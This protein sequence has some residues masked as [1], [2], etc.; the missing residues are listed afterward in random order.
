MRFIMTDWRQ[1]L[2]RKPDLCS[3]QLCASGTRIP[4]TVILANLADGLS[5]DEVLDQ[6]PSLKPEHIDAALAYAA[7]LAEEQV[8][9]PL[10]EL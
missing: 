5:R 1:H 2:T 6:Y 10:G 3:G 9:L 8:I 7:D 4:V